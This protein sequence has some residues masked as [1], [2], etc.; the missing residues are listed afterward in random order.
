MDSTP[1]PRPD[2]QTAVTT[3]SGP[4]PPA[5][6]AVFSPGDRV[7][8]RFRILRFLAQGGMGQVYAAEDLELGEHVA[9]KTVR[10]EAMG[11]E[12]TLLRFKREIYLARKVTHPNVCRTYDVFRHPPEAAE[13]GGPA[14]LVLAME[15]LEGETLADRLRRDGPLSPAEAL[16]LLR[17]MAEG[18]GAAHRAGVVHRDFNSRNVMLVPPAPGTGGGLR[19]VVTDFGLAFA[20]AAEARSGSGLTL[21]G[22]TAGTPAYMS[23]EQVEG[24]EVTVASDLYSFG[25]VLFEMAT[26][27][28]PFV[29]DSPIATAVKRLQEAPPSPRLYVPELPAAWEA[30]VLRCLARDPA[31][32]FATPQEVLAALESAVASP[33]GR[34]FDS[35]AWPPPAETAEKP[36]PPGRPR[37]ALAGFVVLVL[38]VLVLVGYGL[39]QAWQRRAVPAARPAVAVLGFKNLSGRPEAAWLSTAFAEMLT[40]ELAAAGEGKALR[41][42]SGEA[43]AR[44]KRELALPEAQSLAPETLDRLSRLLAAD[45]VVLG[46]YSALGRPEM[47]EKSPLRLDVRLQNAGSGTVTAFAET[48][49]EAELFALIAR[50]GAEL[51]RR[52]GAGGGQAEDGEE[53]RASL[54]ADRTAA[55]LYAEGLA[56]L[57]AAD[58]LRATGTL[59]RAAA[60]QPDHPLVHAALARAWKELGYDARAASEAEKAFALS[61]KLSREERLLVEGQLREVSRA[62]KRAVEVYQALANVFPD[63]PEYGLGLAR[64]QI[65]SGNPR[66]ALRTVEQLASLAD[67]PRL[68]LVEATA[69]GALSDYSRQRRAAERAVA[70]AEEWGARLLVAEG[71]TAIGMAE[72][73]VGQL[74]RSLAAHQQ[75]E[76]IYRSVGD[77]AKV[78]RALNEQAVAWADFG[79][80]DRAQR[81]YEQSLALSREIGHRTGAAGALNNL[82]IVMRRRGDL[83]GSVR[84]QREALATFRELDDKSRQSSTLVSL[85]NVLA[86]QGDFPAARQ[87]Y[88]EALALKRAMG[89]SGV[90][91]LTNLADLQTASGDLTAARRLFEEALALDRKSGDKL[92]VATDL[93]GLSEVL[94]LRGDPAGAAER[95]GAALAEAQAVGD[96]AMTAW[97]HYRLGLVR[98][99]Q[100]DLAAAEREHRQALAL[101][102]EIGEATV[103]DS[104]LALAWLQLA[105]GEPAPAAAEARQLSAGDV[106]RRAEARHLLAA[107]LLAQGD[108]RAACAAL[109]APAGAPAA[110]LSLATRLRLAVVRDRVLAGCGQGA[111][112]R[113]GL[114][115]TL[116]EAEAAGLPGLVRQAKEALSSTTLTPEKGQRSGV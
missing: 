100:G 52:L 48:G 51:R 8:G 45:Y 2:S 102:R 85:A 61:G 39:H 37:N 106:P 103:A 17:Q 73:S 7:A 99:E 3:P 40:T 111:A 25:I 6:A 115:A 64:V 26:G 21:A 5:S 95:A 49:T 28:W 15:L 78:A 29:G 9:L 98:A 18:L 27:Q 84:A 20:H 105:R 96:K 87:A 86:E 1:P 46:S 82:G 30:V 75:A 24:K 50:A 108:A 32:R 31:E 67:D 53:L 58:N 4:V 101:R 70:K 54:P 10:S 109:E 38:A 16:P 35:G 22:A 42:V 44:A 94:L 11:D 76:R 14:T 93:V 83:A 71:Q 59:A 116:R 110:A 33:P 56:Q 36:P 91:V 107:A 66:E 57:R 55:R 89:D 77:R 65:E 79:D 90:Q 68:A 92:G 104:R 74:Q 114:A 88:D 41:T 60:A 62:W 69:A 12:R 23:P 97:A 63:N 81:L 47:G 80:L 113:R 19:A 34:S 72:R 13:T 43:V 112:A